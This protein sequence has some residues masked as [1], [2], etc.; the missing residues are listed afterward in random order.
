MFE[1]SPMVDM[2]QLRHILES[3]ALSTIVKLDKNSMDKLFDL[4]IMMV[5][6]QLTVATGPREVVFITLN[7]LDAMRAMVSDVNAQE[8]V[9]LV[10]QMVVDVS[11]YVN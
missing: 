7:H 5:K 1:K 11:T 6:Y 9:S 8:C 2:L 4:M 3:V 10:H